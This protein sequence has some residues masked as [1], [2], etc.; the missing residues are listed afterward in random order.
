MTSDNRNLTCAYCLRSFKRE[1]DKLSHQSQSRSCH[2][3][4]ANQILPQA[5]HRVFN[6]FDDLSDDPPDLDLDSMVDDLRDD[7]FDSFDRLLATNLGSAPRDANASPT[8]IAPIA[9]DPPLPLPKAPPSESNIIDHFPGA[10]A[11]LREETSVLERWNQ[12]HG[13][14][15]NPYHPFKSKLDWEL[16]RWAKQEAPGATSMDRLLSCNSVCASDSSCFRPRLTFP[17]VRLPNA[18]TSHSRT[19]VSLTRLSTTN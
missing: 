9:P 8:P 16:A 4:L 10:A 17:R 2:D 13:H 18:S 12:K 5:K 7:L 19:C 1:G 11:V 6:D 15:T 3:G 14:K